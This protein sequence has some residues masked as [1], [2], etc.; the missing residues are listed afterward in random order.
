MYNGGIN[1]KGKFNNRNENTRAG[2]EA[3]AGEIDGSSNIR[4][5]LPAG[6]VFVRYSKNGF[7]AGFSCLLVFDSSLQQ[8]R[9]VSRVE[10][11]NDGICGLKCSR[12]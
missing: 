8:G 11:S 9:K 2:R 12:G 3:I 1:G 10:A 7:R 5:G 4:I 6:R